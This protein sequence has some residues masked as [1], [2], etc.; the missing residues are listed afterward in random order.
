MIY[1]DMAKHYGF[2]VSPLI[3]YFLS[4]THMP[5]CI[6]GFLGL[7][8]LLAMPSPLSLSPGCTL[9]SQKEV[10]FKQDGD[11]LIG[12]II[13]VHINWLKPDKQITGQP[14][15]C[16]TLDTMAYSWVQAMVFSINEINRDQTLLPNISL[17]FQIYD[18]CYLIT[19]VL[20]GTAWMLT[21]QEKPI[22]NYRCNSQTSLVAI[23][24]ECSSTFSI[25]MARILGLYMYTQISYFS[26]SP[27]L[28][29]KFQFPS[30]F[31]MLPSDDIQAQGLAQ[32]VVRFGWEWV[33]LLSSPTDY[34]T[35]GSQ[36]LKVELLKLGV[37][38]AFHETFPTVSKAKD[39]K[40]I[41]KVVKGS[42]VKIILV[43]SSVSYLIP[44]VE[45]LSR[46]N[47]TGKVWITSDS[48]TS[49]SNLL[50]REY[51]DI[52]SGTLGFTVHEVEMPG[53]KDF[54][55]KLHP[56]TSPHDIF[57]K[58]LWKEIFKCQ[59]PDPENN[60]TNLT[61]MDVSTMI[62]CTGAE[63]LKEF[64]GKIPREFDMSTSY[65]VYNAVYSVA[66]GL[67][68]MQSCVPG[69]GPFINH[70]CADIRNFKPWQ[71]LHYMKKVRFVNKIGEEIYFDSKGDSPAVYDIVNWQPLSDGSI[72]A[73]KVGS[74]D[75]RAPKGQELSI[76]I[77]AIQWN[78]Q[79][80]EVPR[81][82]CSESC[83]PGYRKAAQQ[84][85][86]LC[87]FDCIPC[88]EGE[89]SNVVDSTI[90]WQC[91]SDQWP[92][93]RRSECVPKRIEYLSYQEVMGIILA[94]VAISFFIITA[95]ILCVFIKY[96]D[97]PIAK[98]NNRELSFLLLG[99]LT[100]SFL[101][102]LLFIGDP[103]QITCLLRQP[104]FGTIFVLC[105]ACVLAK[106]IMVVI[107]FNATKP[108]SNLRGWVGPRVP[109][110]TVSAC[111]FI[112]VLICVTWLLI[113][114]PFPE[115]NMKLKTGI[116]IWQCNECSD[117]AFWCMLG[118]MGLL[119]CVSFLVAFLARKLPDSFNEAKWITFSML[120]FLS[121][122]LSFIP[123]YLSTQGKNTVAVEVFGIISSSAGIL[124]CIFLPKCY[125][126]LLRP[127][128]NT[129]EQ[130]LGKGTGNIKRRK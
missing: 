56:S 25:S 54:L 40:L 116:I 59:W 95:A 36:I 92:N 22:L 108:N 99:A 68:N 104:A 16:D 110:V 74:F 100:L 75:A 67:H 98:A 90:C 14:D 42:S 27:V 84:G 117:V 115:K 111:T 29:D 113:C 94:V 8:V 109:I 11:I 83:G 128:M 123:G 122:W 41:L 17:G 3:K 28:S 70:T 57:I 106:T 89:I 107:A 55:L 76:N 2:Q 88:P 105:V 73:V 32:M 63:K 46:T 120:V 13:P 23:I 62:M 65:N 77:S 33:G 81:S 24:G 79:H 69:E 114:P 82:V 60:L 58:P 52:M 51:T 86:P 85:Q 97:T 121:V 125:I 124:I 118:Y 21:G 44:V 9:Q 43:F 101:C 129:R 126:I 31:R 71:L 47:I 72:Q 127:D 91:A 38:I 49:S 103:Q 19:R 10:G 78:T 34:G 50:K 35:L 102:S 66:H 61:N 4:L 45:E 7:M 53:F 96:R 80:A 48:W 20:R 15:P 87:C 112:Q 18:T 26:T 1:K 39:L 5:V 64:N 130:L 12:G 119:A 6:M 30:F 37:C 93:E